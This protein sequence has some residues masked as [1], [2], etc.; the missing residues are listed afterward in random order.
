MRIHLLKPSSSQT[1]LLDDVGTR[2]RYKRIV[3]FQSQADSGGCPCSSL[4]TKGRLRHVDYRMLR[5]SGARA[6]LNTC[7]VAVIHIAYQGILLAVQTMLGSPFVRT[8]IL[9]IG[10]VSNV[11]LSV[12]VVKSQG[13]KLYVLSVPPGVSGAIRQRGMQHLAAYAGE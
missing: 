1:V 10:H 7:L 11:L 13:T 6:L 3:I 9:A 12:A 4:H 8:I 2:R 5:F